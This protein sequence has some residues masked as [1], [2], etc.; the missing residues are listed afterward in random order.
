[1]RSDC[2]TDTAELACGHPEDEEG[3]NP[4]QMARM[5]GRGGSSGSGVP[6]SATALAVLDAGTY[7][8]VADSQDKAAHGSFALQ[9][10]ITTP[11]GAGTAHDVCSDAEVLTLGAGR[12]VTAEGDTFDAHDDG[13]ASC[14]AVGAGD[15]YYQVNVPQ[16]SRLTAQFSYSEGD[17]VMSLHKTCGGPP[18][19]C[20][21][22]IDETVEAGT[23]Y[24]AVDGGASD[25]IAGRFKLALKTTDVGPKEIACRTAPVLT[26]ASPARGTTRGARDQFDVSCGGQTGAVDRLF[27]VVVTQRSAV[28]ILLETPTFDGV[29][30]LRRTC[31]DTSTVQT[32]NEIQCNDDDQ[33]QT[34]RAR[35]SA[36][37]EPGTYFVVVEGHDP[38]QEGDFTLTMT[39]A[40]GGGAAA[41]AGGPG[42]HRPMPVPHP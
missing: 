28:E 35:V 39:S 37:L 3:S 9:A 10:D 15:V 41:A 8:V 31:F 17:H 23:Y 26:T 2:D 38:G 25:G 1:L 16:R 22:A 4:Q 32:R 14:A 13:K 33:D 36:T 5:R 21:E 40:A 34:S 42:P 19:S 18:V 7:M 24:I 12:E 29:L 11:T 30:S 27:R 6:R 20:G